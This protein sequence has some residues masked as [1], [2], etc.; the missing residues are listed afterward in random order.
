MVNCLTRN[1]LRLKQNSM[2]PR[3]AKRWRRRLL[4]LLVGLSLLI[5]SALLAL[6]LALHYSAPPVIS[7]FAE[8]KAASQ[9]SYVA[10]L[11]RHGLVLDRIRLDF[12]KRQGEWLPLNEVSP[13]FI[14][15]I[16]QSEDKRFYRHKGVDWLALINAAQ[17]HLRLII[18]K[19][20]GFNTAAEV[21]R[22]GA[23]GISMQLA[24]L[25]IPDL[26]ATKFRSYRQK[27]NQ[28]AAALALERQW[29]KQEILE[30]YVN[31]LPFRGE[32][33][34]VTAAAETFFGKYAFGLN[35]REAALLAAMAR[36]P[37][38]SVER[39]T[40]RSCDLLQ[41]MNDAKACQGLAHFVNYYLSLPHPQ[42]LDN[43]HHAFHLA[44]YARQWALLHRQKSVPTSLDA[45][46]QIRVN[47]LVQQ[48]L[49]EIR[50]A[51]VRDAAVIVLDNASGAI[52][53]YVGSS[54]QLSAATE[55]D[56]VRAPRQAASTLKPFLYAQ[57]IDEKR[58]TAAGLLNDSP[59]NL[60][61]GEGLYIPQNHDRNYAGWVSLRVALAS[62]L[63]IPAVRTIVSLG[64]EP[65][66]K[67]LKA[68]H[69]PLHQVSEYYGYSLALGGA[70]MDLLSLSNAYRTLANQGAYSPVW[71]NRAESVHQ[72][73]RVQVFSPEATWI[74][75]DILSDR[76]ARAYTFGLD[77]VL[78]TPFWTAVKTGTSKDMRD[79]WTIGWSS[80]YTVGVW[81]GNSDGRSMQNVYG[82]SGAGPIWYDVMRY[83]HQNKGSQAPPK[84]TAVVSERVHFVGV[85]E[86]D[87]EEFFMAGTAMQEIVALSSLAPDGL[88]PI[89]IQRPINGSVLAID[90]DIPARA[91]KLFLKASIPANDP[92]AEGLQWEI[93]G[94]T[95]GQGNEY[96]WAP[97]RGRYAIVLKDDE[98]NV[99][100]RVSITVR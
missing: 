53:A 12:N 77:S 41:K 37:N 100:D 57:M 11:D 83:L 18:K 76:Q 33:I 85:D 9:S 96:F 31:L 69:L 32:I 97:N 3:G 8:A 91:Q 25:L 23:S 20:L 79:N 60:L 45:E 48:H 36:A 65:F 24:A 75:A 49:M 90:P 66:Y 28:L 74:I 7:S 38:A 93:A 46:L 15:A 78:T 52:L 14:K 1:Y 51:A 44:R 35:P 58:L 89:K 62:S 86:A 40:E 64:V 82:V 88:A 80:D 5:G 54:A 4:Y 34:G 10:I 2:K 19:S 22:G 63:N 16:L 92:R 84:P 17:A 81:V 55:V 13:A 71:W 61:A 30:A 21:G 6:R 99:L 47:E 50:D 67:T 94:Q 72:G 43:Q 42:R 98:G 39:L 73:E 87:R 29:T 27:W 68:L 70:D 95:V 59:L 26:Q 56:H